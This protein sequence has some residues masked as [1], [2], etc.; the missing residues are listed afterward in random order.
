MDEEQ[1]SDWGSSRFLLRS[2]VL[3]YRNAHCLNVVSSLSYKLIKSN[4]KTVSG[5][6]ICSTEQYGSMCSKNVYLFW[7]GSKI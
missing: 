4:F 1:L 6:I 3:L 5:N 2:M 7:I